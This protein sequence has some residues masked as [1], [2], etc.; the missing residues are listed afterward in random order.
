MWHNWRS[1][2]ADLSR[3]FDFIEVLPQFRAEGG[4]V[5]RVQLH[6]V[7]S[8]VFDGCHPRTTAAHG[9]ARHPTSEWRAH[10]TVQCDKRRPLSPVRQ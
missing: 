2:L 4:E 9:N 7:G 5:V 6:G 10:V 3:S 8:R 1:E